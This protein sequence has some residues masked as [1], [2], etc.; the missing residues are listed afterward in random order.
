MNKR[1]LVGDLLLIDAVADK[2]IAKKRGYCPHKPHRKQR[3]FLAIQDLEALYGG[4]A[5]GGKS[6]ALLMAALEHVDK[7]EYSAL[8]L[9]RTFRDLNQP[10]AIMDRARSWLIN[11]DAKWNA[12][13]KRW[14]FPSGA[15]LTF[16]YF[17]KESDKDQY[18]SAEF[19]FIGFDELT[20]FPENWYRFMFSRLRKQEESKVPVKMR[21]ATNP[22]N[23]GHVWVKRRFVD[24]DT[25]EAPFV[26]AL[27]DDNPFID[28]L[29][30]KKSLS[31]LDK[32]TRDQLEK[33]IW[34]ND[35]SGLVY[36]F[37]INRNLI[38][39]P[40]KCHQHI[41]GVDFGA[42]KDPCAF[43]VIGWRWHD[44][45][46]YV[47]KS[48]CKKKMIPS[49][50]ADEIWRLNDE[51]KFNAMIGDCNGLG[52]GFVG[53]ARKRLKLPVE[54]ALKNDKPGY[55]KLY[56]GELEEGKIK[57]VQGQCNQLILEYQDL[58]WHDEGR[59]K[60]SEGFDNH[61]ADGTLYAWRKGQ[62]FLAEQNVQSTRGIKS[63]FA[64]G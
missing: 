35:V 41:L 44:P 55:I 48:Y 10:K 20:Q 53:E 9:R 16:G 1:E 14:T 59:T 37:D 64:F 38:F 43:S 4:A 2:V 36:S 50:A 56:N 24:P 34:R 30:Y 57:I 51:F 17:D 32:V 12:Q 5:G 22:G 11:T 7:P 45:V 8:L 26:P 52:A 42:T 19:H 21:G 15:T 33:G 6:D 40:P 60:E 62:A 47:L 23:I 39:V 31:K 46:T 29:G 63:P 18:A 27:L 61:C 49:E 3:E 25:A 13:A 54:A 58:P 28:Q